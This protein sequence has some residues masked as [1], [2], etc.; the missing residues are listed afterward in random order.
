MVG[1]QDDASVLHL[2][3]IRAWCMIL[4]VTLAEYLGLEPTIGDTVASGDSVKVRRRSLS[5]EE[6]VSCLL[7]LHFLP[8]HLP[9]LDIAVDRALIHLLCRRLVR[10][11]PLISC[12][13]IDTS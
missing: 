7:A 4:R 13:R 1:I 9:C 5:E 8:F 6:L 12:K 3:T 11:A 10:C 2:P